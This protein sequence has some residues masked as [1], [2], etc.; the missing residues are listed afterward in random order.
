MIARALLPYGPEWRPYSI[1]RMKKNP[2]ILGHVMRSALRL[3]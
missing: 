2:Q 1:R 3:S